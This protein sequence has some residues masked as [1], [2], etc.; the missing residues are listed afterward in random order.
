V[1][2]GKHILQHST[3]LAL[4]IILALGIICFAVI[5]IISYRGSEVKRE[6][7][8]NEAQF[9]AIT[10]SL[11]PSV[12][13]TPLA[14]KSLDDMQVSGLLSSDE[15]KSLS[16]MD[17]RFFPPNKNATSNAIVFAFANYYVLPSSEKVFG[18]Y[19]ARSLDGRVLFLSRAEMQNLF[20]RTK[21]EER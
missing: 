12:R 1:R 9:V 16:S 21:G 7:Y 18:T 15:L 13:T 6:F 4:C 17:A 2:I 8:H 3:L 5:W 10:D 11:I 19:V 20:P 14:F